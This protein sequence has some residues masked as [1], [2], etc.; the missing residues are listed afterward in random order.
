MA[1]AIGS[2]LSS[3]T[4][5]TWFVSFFELSCWHSCSLLLP[6]VAAHLGWAA[7]SQKDGLFGFW[8]V[9]LC[10]EQSMFAKHTYVC[11]EDIFCVMPVALNQTVTSVGAHGSPTE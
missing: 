1:G 11:T 3:V 5:N 7:E 2:F 10:A 4:L 6:P 9:D 8:H